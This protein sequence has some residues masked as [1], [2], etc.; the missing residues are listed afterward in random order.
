MSAERYPLFV[1]SKDT[2]QIVERLKTETKASNQ[3]NS[4]TGWHF[5]S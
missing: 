1:T 3:R 2:I 4:E 5:Y